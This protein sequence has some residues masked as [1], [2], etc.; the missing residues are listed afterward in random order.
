MPNDLTKGPTI[1]RSFR[2]TSDTSRPFTGP[3]KHLVTTKNDSTK[4]V[5]TRLNQA[6]AR[7]PICSLKQQ[8]HNS[9]P[10]RLPV[11]R[12][13]CTSDF[14]RDGCNQWPGCESTP[15]TSPQ[16]SQ[17][18]TTAARRL[19]SLLTSTNDQVNVW[20][21]Q[22]VTRE[23]NDLS[24]RSRTARN[25]DGERHTQ[26]RA[27]KGLTR[28]AR[29]LFVRPLRCSLPLAMGDAN[30]LANPLFKPHVPAGG[31]FGKGTQNSPPKR[32]QKRPAQLLSNY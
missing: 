32:H 4:A 24:T 31:P 30:R 10:A 29:C 16:P 27:S 22:R 19:S 2:G 7:Q 18:P 9:F 21:Y 11:A 6:S 13:R 1:N 5:T 8:P 12:Y 28:P 3:T 25:T 14:V 17:S 26:Q 15:C 20:P 23:A